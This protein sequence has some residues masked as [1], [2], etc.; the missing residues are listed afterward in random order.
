M[1]V[2]HSVFVVL[3]RFAFHC[4]TVSFRQATTY[5][6]A[7]YSHNSAS[8][9]HSKND[10]VVFSIPQPDWQKVIALLG[11][12]LY[13]KHEWQQLHGLFFFTD[14]ILLNGE[15][16]QHLLPSTA[17]SLLNTG[18]CYKI[19]HNQ[20]ESL[21]TSLQLPPTLAIKTSFTSILKRTESTKNVSNNK[22]IN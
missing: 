16:H 1:A 17:H 5:R 22:V 15:K 10:V 6:K 18:D 14:K 12:V 2:R 13:Y 20:N 4:T 19:R 8:K 21:L 7:I 3:C 11:H 9:E